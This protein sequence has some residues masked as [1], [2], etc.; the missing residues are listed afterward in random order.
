MKGNLNERHVQ[1]PLEK[2]RKLCMSKVEEKVSL[3]NGW[4]RSLILEGGPGAVLKATA[5]ADLHRR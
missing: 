3:G 1:D 5:S 4:D 2:L